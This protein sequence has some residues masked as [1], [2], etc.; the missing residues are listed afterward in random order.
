MSEE[1]KELSL[2]NC[3]CDYINNENVIKNKEI[4]DHKIKEILN[5]L[6]EKI[7]E[8]VRY[9]AY[10]KFKIVCFDLKDE[11]I[12][13]DRDKLLKESNKKDQLKD[14]I[15]YVYEAI[16]LEPDDL[17]K[18]LF[19]YESKYSEVYK[20]EDEY[21]KEISIK[22]AMIRISSK[23]R[24][25]CENKAN[26]EEEINRYL[27]F[28]IISIIK[29]CNYNSK[30][31]NLLKKINLV[32]MNLKNLI[33]EGY[34]REEKD[35]C[36][37]E[38]SIKTRVKIIEDKNKKNKIIKNSI[39]EYMIENNSKQLTTKEISE[40]VSKKLFPEFAENDASFDLM[41]NNELEDSDFGKGLES[42]E[43]RSENL[44]YEDE[45]QICV[46]EYLKEVAK[47]LPIKYKQVQAHIALLIRLYLEW[48][49][50]RDNNNDFL[51]REDLFDKFD[52]PNDE[53]ECVKK[54]LNGEK[55]QNFVICE[56]G[57]NKLVSDGNV[58]NRLKYCSFKCFELIIESCF[59]GNHCEKGDKIR[60]LFIR[61]LVDFLEG[62]YLEVIGEKK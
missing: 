12:N 48:L 37:L 4:N 42:D 53:T 7:I 9:I 5:K 3:I 27:P 47:I 19:D 28:D 32:K 8:S 24:N 52:N 49:K 2:G 57:K 62:L 22:K 45:A 34:I 36:Y 46:N 41:Y 18:D 20:T 54:I 23:I 39:F 43:K 11:K 38:E 56:I 51:F 15:L 61:K 55:F 33:D 25:I 14:V 50:N 16:L 58:T 21:K 26:S 44:E 13:N 31:R 17:Q 30:Y 29:E 35:Y 40:S 60:V 10:K 6:Y 1:Q 59:L